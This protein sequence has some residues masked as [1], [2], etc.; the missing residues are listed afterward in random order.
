MGGLLAALALFRRREY[1][2]ARTN[3]QQH[4]Q[5]GAQACQPPARPAWCARKARLLVLYMMCILCLH[6]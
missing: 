6:L 3:Y 5:A 1:K 2:D 4:N